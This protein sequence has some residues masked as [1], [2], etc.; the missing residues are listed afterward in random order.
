MEVADQAYAPRTRPSAAIPAPMKLAFDMDAVEKWAQFSS[1][2]NPIH[3]ELAHARLAGLDAL[4]VHGMLA[5]MPVKDAVAG[6]IE[7]G[8]WMKFKSLLRNPIPHGAPIAFDAKPA[9]EGLSFQVR[10]SAGQI[11]HFRGT[12][13]RAEDPVAELQG[14]SVELQTALDCSHVERFAQFYP[15]VRQRW[16]GLD[17]II[18]SEFMRTRLQIVEDIAQAHL[19]G[20]GADAHTSRVVVQSSHSVTFDAAFFG[21]LGGPDAWTGFSHGMLMPE[22]IASSNQLS[23]T[24]SLPVMWQD[25]LVMLVELGLVSRFGTPN[26][27]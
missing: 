22:M 14:E 8:G 4:I 20:L 2:R 26:S 7:P 17:A 13:R 24:V 16:I 21:A 5:L 10:G 27:N 1:D 3:F 11:E 18:F 15:D 19:L 12:Y 9:A 25:R 23:G 6:A